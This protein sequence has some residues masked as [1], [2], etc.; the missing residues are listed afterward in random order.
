MVSKYAIFITRR[1]IGSIIAIF[2]IAALNFLLFRILPGNP[3]ELLFRNPNLTMEQIKALEAQFGLDKPLWVQFVLYLVNFFEGNFGISF[4]YRVPVMDVLIPRLINTLILLIPVT[5]VAVILGTLTGMY[6]AWKRGTRTDVTILTT[7][8]GLYSLPTFWIGGIL[9]LLSYYYLH[10]P[11]SGMFTYGA[12]Y[13]N[14]WAMLQ[15]F[16]RHFI[17]PFITLTLVIFGEFT[18]ILRNAMIDVLTEDYVRTAIAQGFPTYRLLRRVALRNAL[19]PTVSIIAIN[20]GLVV[21]GSVLTETVFAWPG[22][23]RLIYEAIVHRDY[24]T[25]QGAFI[26]VTVSVVV[27]NFIADIL[28][29]YLD[30]RVR[31]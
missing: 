17:L 1:L 21:A 4:Y 25:L 22:V 14:T 31:H 13:P 26:I 9:A 24:P 11:T 29:G 12:T 5:V 7:A 6:A 8:M 30:P 10:L 20:I 27:A 18:I 19:L 16:M 28:Y 2:A 15:D 3:I 23:G